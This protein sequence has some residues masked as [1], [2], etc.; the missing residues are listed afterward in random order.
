[1]DERMRDYMRRRR[2]DGRNPYGSRGG[3][4]TTRRPRRDR[5]EDYRYDRDR[6]YRG[7][8]DHREDYEPR[9]R[10][11]Y[12]DIDRSVDVVGYYGATPFSMRGRAGY[13]DYAYTSG[14]SENVDRVDGYYYPPMPP[15]YDYEGG[16]LTDDEMMHWQRRMKESLPESEAEGI[17]RE[18]VLKRAK[19]MGLEFDKFSENEFYTAFLMSYTDNYKTFGKSALDTY[20]RLAKNFLCD[21]DAGVRYGE[22]LATYYDAIVK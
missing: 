2:M 18:K 14:I 3:Y 21:D 17:S 19:D 20:I 7:R 6:E 22:K 9:Y 16:Y 4:V 1:M 13:D 12:D 8:R 5:N 11:D 10:R 15:I